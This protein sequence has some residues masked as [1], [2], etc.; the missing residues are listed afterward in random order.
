MFWGDLNFKPL[1]WADCF[2]SF[3]HTQASRRKVPVCKSIEFPTNG[4]F[5]LTV[6]VVVF[7]EKLKFCKT[8]NKDAFTDAHDVLLVQLT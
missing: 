1:V 2:K 8:W 4:D 5:S 3:M 6:N 7:Q